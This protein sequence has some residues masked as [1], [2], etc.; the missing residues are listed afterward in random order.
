MDN[1][2]GG[3]VIRHKRQMLNMSAKEVCNGI[4]EVTGKKY[5]PTRIYSVESGQLRPSRKLLT[6]LMNVLKISEE[7]ARGISQDVIDILDCLNVH[8]NKRI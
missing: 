1:F 8:G 3:E 4:A 2:K 6:G 7:E 5:S